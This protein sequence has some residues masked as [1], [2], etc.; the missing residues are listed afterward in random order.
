MSTTTVNTGPEAG[1]ER[2]TVHQHIVEFVSDSGEGAQTAGQLFGTIAARMGNGVWTVEII[3]AEIEPPH[4]SRAGASGN[5]VRIASGP[6]TNVGE[7]ADVVVAFNEQ[8]LYSRIDAGALPRG[9]RSC[10]LDEQVGANDPDQARSSGSYAEAVA[11]FERPAASGWLRLPIEEDCKRFIDRRPRSGKNMWARGA[12]VRRSTSCDLDSCFAS[13]VRRRGSR[14][15]GETVVA[16]ELGAA[17]R[18]GYE[19]ASSITLPHRFDLS[20]SSRR[21]RSP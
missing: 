8:V 4:R 18:P 1:S 6:V 20:L 10:Y 9:D 12:A 15:K 17:W 16:E 5:R 11:D 7:E 14:K 2:Q 19:W 3:P 21:P 13:K